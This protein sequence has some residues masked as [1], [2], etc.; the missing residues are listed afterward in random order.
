M[1]EVKQV[2]AKAIG[3]EA[4]AI[5][6]ITAST[7]L[8]ECLVS[9]FMPFS[10]IYLKFSKYFYCGLVSQATC[11]ILHHLKYDHCLVTDINKFI[12]CIWL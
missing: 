12:K 6:K 10:I 1:S 8:S 9:A 3:V 11:F 5:D 4:K 7:S 2:E